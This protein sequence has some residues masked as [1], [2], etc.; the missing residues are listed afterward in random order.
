MS[1]DNAAKKLRK[2]NGNGAKVICDHAKS[3]KCP[4][5]ECPHKQPHPYSEGTDCSKTGCQVKPKA[6]G[7]WETIAVECVACSKK[8]VKGST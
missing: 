1:D 8:T 2:K 3:K 7:N 4:L 5:R 6:D